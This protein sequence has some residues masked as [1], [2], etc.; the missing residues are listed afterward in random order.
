MVLEIFCGTAGV[1]AAFKKLGFDVIAVDK[2]VPKSPKV[3]I[4]KLDLTQSCNQQLVFDW[5]SLPQ[6]R[7]VFLAPPCGT[8][9]LACNIQ[10]PEEPD[11][12]QPLRSWD[13][14]DG[15]QNLTELDFLRVSQANC[16]YE[17]TAACQDLCAKLGKFCACENLRDSLFWRTTP[18]LDRESL[19]DDIE[20]V[21][22]ACAYGSTRPKWTKLVANFN[23]MSAVNQVCPGNHFHEPWGRHGLR[24]QSAPT[25]N[26]AARA[27]AQNQPAS[28]KDAFF[29]RITNTN[30]SGSCIMK[31]KF[32]RQ[33]HWISLQQSCCIAFKWGEMTCS[34]LLWPCKRN[35]CNGCLKQFLR[36]CQTCLFH[37]W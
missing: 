3:M 4:T 2:F 33:L 31:L 14:P 35:A 15:L 28:N 34:S 25:G 12:P 26:L 9:S 6:V 21:H 10:D 36:I 20:Q 19:A 7:V 8:A 29:C 13:E 24:P 32:G 22:R 1:S 37:V 11:L 30:L 18:W 5:I 27:F 23:E 17:F 16:L